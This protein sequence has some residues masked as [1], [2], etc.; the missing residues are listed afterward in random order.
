MIKGFYRVTSN[1]EFVAEY[2]NMITSNGLQAIN[3][4]LCGMIPDWAGSIAIGSLNSNPTTS[5]TQFLDYEYLRYPTTLK[6]YVSS[7]AINKISLKTSLDPSLTFQAYELGI[8]PNR[9]TSSRIDHAE[10][11]NFSGISNGSSTWSVGINTDNLILNP[12]FETGTTASWT[13][14]GGLNV[15]IVTSSAYSGTYAMQLQ[16]NSNVSSFV[17]NIYWAQP[18]LFNLIGGVS[19][20]FSFYAKRVSGTNPMPIDFSLFSLGAGGG[21][22]AN[23]ANLTNDW[24]KISITLPGTSVVTGTGV[25]YINM[26]GAVLGDTVLI[27]SVMLQGPSSPAITASGARS[28][29]LTVQ[30]PAG[31]TVTSPISMGTGAYNLNDRIDILYYTALPITSVSTL[32][33]NLIDDSASAN[34]WTAVANIAPTASGIYTTSRLFFTSAPPDA[35]TNNLSSCQVKFEGS[36]TILLDHM[37]MSTGE[38]KNIDSILTSRIYSSNSSPLITKAYGQP[39]EIEY[40]IQVT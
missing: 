40:Y 11:S 39:M 38:T 14:N 1:G 6:G 16:K 32:T 19:Y 5:S 2:E 17:Q 30:L 24:Q 18:A 12:S 8:F 13:F 22:V 29:S 31:Q 4:F 3:E 20:T 34:K 15:S 28:D 35:F 37:K 21:Y 25:A 26:S 9:V 36:G 33:V 10:I 27:D 7:S 23:G